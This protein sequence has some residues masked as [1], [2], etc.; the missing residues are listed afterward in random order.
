[1]DTA[2]LNFLL[3]LG[4]DLLALDNLV[5]LWALGGDAW[6]TAALRWQLKLKG[7]ATTLFVSAQANPAFQWVDAVLAGRTKEAALVL[8]ELLDAGEEPLRLLALL[9]KSVGILAILESGGQAHGQPDF[10]VNKLRSLAN[11][12]R[13]R[14]LLSR[15]AELDRAF[16]STA[17][18]A[19]AALSTL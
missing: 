19:R 1:M 3:N 12:G 11:K 4:E 9:N 5:E 8:N 6:A 18:N 15:C 7:A 17:I 2:R 16:K 10:L 14:K 13:G